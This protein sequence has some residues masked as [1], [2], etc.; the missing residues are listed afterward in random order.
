MTEKSAA[1][2]KTK[3][4]RKQPQKPRPL[5]P[6]GFYGRRRMPEAVESE[7]QLQQQEA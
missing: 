7:D 6:S 1:S 4:S 5:P 3:Q 2:C